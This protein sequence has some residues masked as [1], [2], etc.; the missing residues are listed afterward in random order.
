MRGEGARLTTIVAV[1]A[2]IAVALAV[3]AQEPFRVTYNLDRSNP[4]QIQI[5]GT[6]F[7]DSMQDVFDVT[8]TAEALD[9][10]GK[11]V[12]RGISFVSARIPGQGNAPFVCKVPVVAAA[13]R[14]RAAVSAYRAGAGSQAP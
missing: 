1:L 11:V 14:Y 4:E 7:N 2:A 8:V 12:A 10:R 3:E 5:T 6:V 13:V 9:A